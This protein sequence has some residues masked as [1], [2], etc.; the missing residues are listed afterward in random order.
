MH[1]VQKSSSQAFSGSLR[2][3]TYTFNCNWVWRLVLRP[4][5][6]TARASTAIPPAVNQTW[7]MMVYVSLCS[8]MATLCAGTHLLHL[9]CGPC[10]WGSCCQDI[11]CQHWKCH[12]CYH[13]HHSFKRTTEYKVNVQCITF[14]EVEP[15]TI[16]KH[17]SSRWLHLHASI[18]SRG[19]LFLTIPTLMNSYRTIIN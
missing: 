11:T 2:F 14:S 8:L 18:Y 6:A 17:V 9:P 3:S 16:L 10:L 15:F 5:V 4:A 1:Y 12:N 19:M 7:V 13:F